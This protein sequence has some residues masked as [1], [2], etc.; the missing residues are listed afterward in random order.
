MSS[1]FLN[2]PIHL[3][4]V[5]LMEFTQKITK[6]IYL[7]KF[8]I[9]QLFRRIYHELVVKCIIQCFI[10]KRVFR[11]F[12]IIILLNVISLS[13]IFT[14]NKHYLTIVSQVSSSLQNFDIHDNDANK[15]VKSR[16]L[17]QN[18][19]RYS[20]VYYDYLRTSKTNYI[21]SVLLPTN[22][23]DTLI[24]DNLTYIIIFIKSTLD[25]FELRQ[26][27]RKTWANTQCYI[28]Y[29]IKPHIYFT[30]GR[31][32][33]S[34]WS[35]ASLQSKILIEHKQYHDILQFD[36][37]ESYYNL[38][39]K[40]I[41]TIEY[42]TVHC[43]IAKFILFIDQDFIVNPFNL[44]KYFFSIHNQQYTTFVAGYVIKNAKPFRLLNSKWFISKHI[45][46]FKSYPNYP[47]GGTIIFSRPVIIA[48]NKKLRNVQLFPFDDV[49][50]G[51]IL[52]KLEISIH[53]LSSILLSNN[54]IDIRQQF[55]TAHFKGI[56]YLLINI[57]KSLRL[58]EQC[59]S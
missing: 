41:G 16:H 11:I 22:H 6:F 15:L 27:L 25:E 51:I 26:S 52:E 39:R 48:L 29:G 42:A 12:I 31:E 3:I 30:L 13:V 45:Y 44:A 55:M 38:T 47:I 1:C 18:N 24:N 2:N 9:I 35:N 40:L 17:K 46:P 36:F 49:L 19:K 37:I 5:M 32:N 58:D 59:F 4:R 8:T 21:K 34:T 23:C 57:W 56:S 33:L 50:I 20:G 43:P 14:Y 10:V 7:V 53:H 28:K 54:I